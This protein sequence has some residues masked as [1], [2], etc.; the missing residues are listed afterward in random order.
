MNIFF[1]TWLCNTMRLKTTNVGENPAAGTSHQKGV[2]SGQELQPQIFSTEITMLPFPHVLAHLGGG[3]RGC[4]THSW[5]EARHPGADG[6]QIW[7]W[8]L[9]QDDAQ[10]NTAWPKIL[11]G[12]HEASELSATK[13][14]LVSEMAAAAATPG[15][16][17]VREEESGA[18]TAEEERFTAFLGKEQL[19]QRRSLLTKKLKQRWQRTYRKWLLMEKTTH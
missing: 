9:P 12:P 8:C 19:Q 17:R 2:C 13:T 11:R 14:E 18:N 5:P 3:V 16:A 10:S 1:L 15:P 6:R 7:R 4:Q